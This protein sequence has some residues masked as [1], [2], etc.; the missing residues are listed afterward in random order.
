MTQFQL[1]VTGLAVSL[2]LSLSVVFYLRKPL[3]QL[4]VE[5]CGTPDRARFWMQ[6]TNLSFL[7]T[8]MLM[9][10][11]YRPYEDQVGYYFLS[12]HLGRTLFGLLGVTVFLTLTMSIFISRTDKV[13][14]NARSHETAS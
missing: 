13:F 12:G 4:L 8:S 11:S 9:A 7:L 2:L 1:Y 5:V 6:I 14:L 10:L 3:Y